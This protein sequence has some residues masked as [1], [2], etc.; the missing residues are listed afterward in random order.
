LYA[1]GITLN[2]QGKMEISTSTLYGG[3]S[4]RTRF[5]NALENNYDRIADLFGGT[6]G[7][8]ESLD[9]L[10]SQFTSRDGLLVNK[11]DSLKAQL[12]KNTKDRDA[13]D[14]YIES[15]E[16]TLRQRYGALDSTLGQLQS[17]SSM[18]VSQLASLPKYN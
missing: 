1:L 5:N 14:R 15:Y 4:G 7:I 17:T 13:F 18:L 12:K 8:S 6:N 3:D 2:D 9:D 10:I 11:E 16:E